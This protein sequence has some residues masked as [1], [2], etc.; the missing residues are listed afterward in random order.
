MADVGGFKEALSAL[1][2]LLP[3]VPEALAALSEAQAALS[4]A[5]EQFVA[6]VETRQAEAAELF[7]R[8]EV[9]L[10]GMAREAADGTA[11]TEQDRELRDLLADPALGFEEAVAQLGALLAQ[12]QEDRLQELA[13]ALSVSQTNVAAVQSARQSL[14]DGLAGGKR[15]L[16]GAGDA[17]LAAV[18]Q[19]QSVVEAARGTVGADVEQVGTEMDTQHTTQERELEVLRRDVDSY[20]AA[21]VERID[22][23]RDVMRRDT[24]LM[25]ENLRDRLD[26]LGSTLGRALANLREELGDLDERLREAAEEGAEGRQSLAPYFEDLENLLPQLRQQIAHVREAAAVVGIPF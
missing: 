26:D 15:L 7:P 9:S 14:H 2:A 1:Q 21:F 20:E 11:Q 16:A 8:L 19:L 4:D 6:T 5:A 22:R 24:D 25:L 10:A 13:R 12:K 17:S 18:Q 3:R 23:V